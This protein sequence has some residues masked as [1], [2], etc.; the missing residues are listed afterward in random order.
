MRAVSNTRKSRFSFIAHW[1]KWSIKIGGRLTEMRVSLVNQA[2]FVVH[3]SSQVLFFPE[4][5]I[6]NNFAAL[7]FSVLFSPLLREN[8]VQ[9]F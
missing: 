9:L 7:F 6:E 3:P 2:I 8:P 4:F 5:N 1:A